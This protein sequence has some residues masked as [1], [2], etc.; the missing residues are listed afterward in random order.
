MEIEIIQR[1]SGKYSKIETEN[2]ESLSL[3]RGFLVNYKLK[4]TMKSGNVI[5]LETNDIDDI[6]QILDA[7][8]LQ[9][10]YYY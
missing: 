2:I 8:G 3:K 4:I 9:V 1:P 7:C 6:Q 10:S 5:K